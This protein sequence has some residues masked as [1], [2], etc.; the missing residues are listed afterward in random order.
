MIRCFGRYRGLHV[1][2]KDYMVGFVGCTTLPRIDTPQP[3]QGA[4]LLS[5]KLSPTELR[6]YGAET[7]YPWAVP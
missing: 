4:Q 1:R 5:S 7:A 2:H 6:G 3:I